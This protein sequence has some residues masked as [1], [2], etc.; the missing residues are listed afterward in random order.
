[1]TV[2]RTTEVEEPRE[3]KREEMVMRG[4][5]VLTLAQEQRWLFLLL[6]VYHLSTYLVMPPDRRDYR[7]TVLE[8]LK[9]P[10]PP[11]HTDPIEICFSAHKE[12]PK[13]WTEEHPCVV[14][15]KP[16]IASPDPPTN[17]MKSIVLIEHSP[18]ATW[19]VPPSCFF[20]AFFYSVEIN[21][22]LVVISVSL[23][24]FIESLIEQQSSS[25]RLSN[26]QHVGSS[27]E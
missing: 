10:P 12:P 17:P 27:H 2:V 3:E 8:W 24:S 25:D 13:P 18:M 4:R 7:E 11:N 1:L 15:R 20:V 19:K 26:L 22:R 16:G 5:L 23:S 6:V 21:Y 14:D 9:K